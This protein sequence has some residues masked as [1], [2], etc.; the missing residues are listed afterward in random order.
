[1][2]TTPA[3]ELARIKVQHPGWSIQMSDGRR[4]V[5]RRWLDGGRVQQVRAPTLSALEHALWLR[6]KFRNLYDGAA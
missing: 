3:A 2:G 1:M 4:F 5:A 6:E